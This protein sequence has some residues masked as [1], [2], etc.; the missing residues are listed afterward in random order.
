MFF[1]NVFLNSYVVCVKFDYK[2]LFLEMIITRMHKCSM[3]MQAIDNHRCWE[4]IN[5]GYLHIKFIQ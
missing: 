3:A 2:F 1:C 4:I 5:N